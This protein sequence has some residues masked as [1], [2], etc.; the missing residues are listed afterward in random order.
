MRSRACVLVGLLPYALFLALA[1]PWLRAMPIWDGMY[2]FDCVLRATAPPY[3]FSAFSCADHPPGYLLL[4]GW[5]QYFLHGS[6]VA[7][8][9]ANVAWM[10]FGIAGVARLVALVGDEAGAAIER[11]LVVA[12]FASAPLV[13]A[14]TYHFSADAG[15]LAFFPWA[16]D[17][18]L[19]RRTG[20]ALLAG[21]V[22]VLAKE[23]G[24][25]L[26]GIAWLASLALAWR[27]RDRD[28]LRRGLVLVL[29]MLAAAV[30]VAVREER[31]FALID[32]E[33]RFNPGLGAGTAGGLAI[34]LLLN[35][36]WV[37]WSVPLAA[38]LLRRL[39]GARDVR[40]SPREWCLA[41][42]WVAVVAALTRFVPFRNPRY[43]VTAYVP[44]LLVSYAL[45]R[46]AMPSTVRAAFL[47]LVIVLNLAAS[48]RT[49]DPVS[50]A[51]FGAAKYG[52]MRLHCRYWEPDKGCWGRDQIVYNRQFLEVQA[53]QN[54]LFR[55][56]RPTSD[57]TFVVAPDATY[58][59]H[60]ALDPE[61]FE[62]TAREGP[63]VTPRFLTA[64]EVLAEARPAETLYVLNYP[65]LGFTG[66][67]RLERRYHVVERAAH[68]TPR[69]EIPVTVMR[70]N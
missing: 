10:L 5:P 24:L 19:R 32:Q 68:G 69:L 16:L 25:G 18:L 62:R 21:T 66:I 11:A 28:W 63:V 7:L 47:V 52:E 46:R 53:A 27:S 13:V 9:V 48:D 39:S 34:V 61:S 44:L 4:A 41:F 20:Q 67:P 58:F 45:L 70:R 12:V 1:L 42:V 54:A 33:A 55:D 56:L 50:I 36:T 37:L 51:A 14:V 59:M 65:R 35:F 15:L 6:A 29:P 43:F 57:T 3:P 26:Y 60:G 40:L 23:P 22:L 49:V 8:N 64:T 30:Y 17:G 38:C 31:G 2:Y